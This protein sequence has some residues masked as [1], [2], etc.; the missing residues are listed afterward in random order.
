MASNMPMF[1]F[2]D[3]SYVFLNRAMEWEMVVDAATLPVY[4]SGP[5][6][7]PSFYR[8]SVQPDINIV[9]ETGDWLNTSWTAAASMIRDDNA[10]KNFVGAVLQDLFAAPGAGLQYT[11]CA[12]PQLNGWGPETTQARRP[13]A[14][15]SRSR[16]R[17]TSPPFF[18]SRSSSPFCRSLWP[19][20]P[21]QPVRSVVVA[22]PVHHDARA[23]P[24]DDRDR[25]TAAARA[26]CRRRLYFGSMQRDVFCVPWFRRT[27]WA[28]SQAL[29]PRSTCRC[30]T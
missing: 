28:S 9:K 13:V 8:T 4:E 15:R 26:T 6:M 7:R 14:S 12:E 30:R 27:S 2:T 3:W 22:S 16:C 21:W 20:A 19:R 1:A 5:Q 23:T 24:R 17:S 11:I 18:R 10:Y 25:P 29:R